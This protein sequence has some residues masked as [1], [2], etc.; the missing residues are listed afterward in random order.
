MILLFGAR[1]LRE[2]Q[3]FALSQTENREALNSQKYQIAVEGQSFFGGGV[4]V[5]GLRNHLT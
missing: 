3:H 1:G 5:T 4:P 2:A